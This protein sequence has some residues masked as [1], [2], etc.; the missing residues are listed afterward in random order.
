MGEE[1]E[2]GDPDAIVQFVCTRREDSVSV[3]YNPID[4]PLGDGKVLD[5]RANLTVDRANVALENELYDLLSR[6]SFSSRPRKG[7][8]L[9]EVGLSL[10]Q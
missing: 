2:Q 7:C 3:L 10:V 6:I 4:D 5:E 9:I 1:T 8:C